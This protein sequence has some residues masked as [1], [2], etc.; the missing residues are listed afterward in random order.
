MN[1]LS[2]AEIVLKLGKVDRLTEDS[3]GDKESV[4]TH[5][6]MIIGLA[7][8]YAA[9]FGFS[10]KLTKLCVR[11][12]LMHD[13]AEALC[14]DTPT[15]RPLSADELSAKNRR[16]E[17]AHRD[18]QA[19]YIFNTSL[20]NYNSHEAQQFIHIL[21]KMCPKIVHVVGNGKRV[22]DREGVSLEDLIRYHRAQETALFSGQDYVWIEEM[23]NIFR[24][25]CVL[26]EDALVKG[27]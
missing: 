15:L 16:E 18:V 26:C 10:D 19:S 27:E 7:L 14:G 1:N 21:D 13:M 3:N 4:T 20:N 2:F 11:E 6:V 9:I 12:A 17:A 25:A 8:H 24:A 22:C 5:T 23:R